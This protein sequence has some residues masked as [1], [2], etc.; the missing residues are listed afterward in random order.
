MLDRLE[1]AAEAVFEGQ[2][3]TAGGVYGS[4]RDALR[5]F[6]EAPVPSVEVDPDLDQR[7]DELAARLWHGYAVTHWTKPNLR[8]TV[9]EHLKALVAEFQ[10][11]PAGVSQERFDRIHAQLT[12]TQADYG[13]LEHK[14]NELLRKGVS[15]ETID[16]IAKWYTGDSDL[17]GTFREFLCAILQPKPKP[18]E[19]Q[20][21]EGEYPTGRVRV[22]DAVP[23]VG[24]YVMTFRYQGTGLPF[25]NDGWLDGGKRWHYRE[26]R[27]EL[28][29]KPPHEWCA[30]PKRRSA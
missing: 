6:F 22:E 23:R 21:W 13:E 19:P 27:G 4:I 30:L 14:Y 24:D 20:V 29:S 11:A 3:G 10:P 17:S 8:A 9:D 5:P 2:R 7:I 16:E 18:Q 28:M 26:G 15:D 1:E 12:D 25:V